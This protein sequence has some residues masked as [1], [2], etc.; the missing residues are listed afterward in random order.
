[1]KKIFFLTTVL[2][3]TTYLAG[4]FYPEENRVEN[5]IAYPD[6]LESVRVA[7]ENFQED[8]G[9]LPIRTFEENT[10]L[11]HRYVVDFNQLVPR[12]LQQ[13]P[14]TALE[15]GGVFQY[16]LWDVEDSLQVR[17]VDLTSINEIQRLYTRVNEHIRKHSYAPVAEVLDHGLFKLDYEELGYS[18]EPYV[19]SPYYE[20]FLPLLLTN[21]GEV[22]IDYR[23]DLNMA[24]QEY[25]HDF[26]EGEDI[27]PILLENT[28]FVPTRSVAY[29]L[30]ENGEPQYDMS[31]EK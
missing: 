22:V 5:Q 26:Q 27:R 6:Q 25:E 31:L 4:C 30:D 3:L 7:V 13:A 12:Y 8:T 21:D 20:T 23:I 2:L 1:M 14:G 17:V 10:P 29:T 15:N 11:Y 28:Y 16:V 24:L 18:S 9:V 19:K